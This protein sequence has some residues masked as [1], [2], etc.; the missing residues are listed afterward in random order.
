MPHIDTVKPVASWSHANPF[1]PDVE[2]G[3]LYGLG[4]NDCGG[5]GLCSLQI[6]RMLTEKSLGATTLLS[7]FRRRGFGKDGITPTFAP[8]IDLAIVGEPR[9]EPAVVER[10]DGAGCDCSW[11]RADMR[12][13]T[14]KRYHRHWM[15]CAEFVTTSSK[16]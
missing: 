3:V 16:K 8:H 11:Q 7:G 10:T 13:E 5:G 2:D 12:Q 9:Y 4:S 6:F 1:S 15:I 14:S